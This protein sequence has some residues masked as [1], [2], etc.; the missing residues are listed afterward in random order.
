LALPGAVPYSASV[1]LAFGQR[2]G[3]HDFSRAAGLS[4]DYW[5]ILATG[6]S[7]IPPIL[8]SPAVDAIKG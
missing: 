4:D 2:N 3:A 1:N 6:L 7:I 8:K 5:N